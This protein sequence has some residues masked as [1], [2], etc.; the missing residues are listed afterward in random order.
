MTGDASIMGK[1]TLVL[2]CCVAVG[3]LWARPT[4][5]QEGRVDV[6]PPGRPQVVSLPK[7]SPLL[8]GA[9]KRLDSAGVTRGTD[10]RL[11]QNVLP[12]GPG[13]GWSGWREIPGNGRTLSGPETAA[14]VSTLYLVV[15]GTD[16][17]IY[18]NQL[19]PGQ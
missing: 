13:G 11:Y 9:L 5:S 17:G 6:G 18:V 1:L 7:L 15:Q 3:T 14:I 10:D 8:A 4:A 2:I 16:E 19:T 12:P